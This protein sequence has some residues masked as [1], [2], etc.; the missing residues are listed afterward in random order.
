[1]IVTLTIPNAE[2]FCVTRFV[3]HVNSMIK[4]LYGSPRCVANILSDKWIRL[5][6]QELRENNGKQEYKTVSVY[7]FISR[8]DYFT[9]TMGE[10]VNGGIYKAAGFKVPA[11][12]HRGNIYDN[13][14]FP[15]ATAYGIVDLPKGRKAKT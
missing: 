14:T 1:M 4:D 8:Q 5:E 6:R 12:H 7:G 13:V 9:K 2:Q 3:D 15:C 11:K 10:I